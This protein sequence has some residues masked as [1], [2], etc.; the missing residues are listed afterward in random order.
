MPTKQVIKNKNLPIIDDMRITVNQAVTKRIRQLLAE[1]K[2]TMYRLALN[3][4]ILHST[5]NRIMKDKH[6]SSKLITL[7]QIAGG[8]DM[9]IWDFLND[10]L[11]EED[12]L[13]L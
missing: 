8:F 11:F 3:S 6:N 1:K 13:K 5:L 2:I 7:I 10:P 12:N 4:G 9:T